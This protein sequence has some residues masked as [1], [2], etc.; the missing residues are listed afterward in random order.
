MVCGKCKHEF[1]WMCLGEY[2]SYTHSENRYCPARNAMLVFSL[3]LSIFLLNQKLFYNVQ[4][5]Y[6]F[7]FYLLKGLAGTLF[8]DLILASVSVYPMLVY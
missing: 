2:R 7:E 4:W 6:Y 8:I 3:M 1:C 5:F